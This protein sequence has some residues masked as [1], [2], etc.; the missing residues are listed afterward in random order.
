MAYESDA[1]WLH[2]DVMIAKHPKGKGS[3]YFR[4]IY[5][6]P[7]C[8]CGNEMRERRYDEKPEN[9]SDRIEFNGLAYDY[10]L[11]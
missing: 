1:L 10:C 8:G 3:W 6:C 4:Y 9:P 7:V 11:L 2:Q 5:E